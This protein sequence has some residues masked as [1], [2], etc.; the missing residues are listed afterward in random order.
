MV[1]TYQGGSYP[2]GANGW[3]EAVQTCRKEMQFRLARREEEIDE[4]VGPRYASG[5]ADNEKIPMPTIEQ[6][7]TTFQGEFV[8]NNPRVIVDT[9]FPELKADAFEVQQAINFEIVRQNIQ[10]VFEEWVNQSFFGWAPLK[11]GYFSDEAYAQIGGSY[12]EKGVPG[13][14][15]VSPDDW[16][17]DVFSRRQSDCLFYGELVRLEWDYAYES[18]LYDKEMLDNMGP[19]GGVESMLHRNEYGSRRSEALSRG[20]AE[21]QPSYMKFLQCW[22]LYLPRE[23]KLVWV[24]NWGTPEEDKPGKFLREAPWNGPACGPY[25]M[26]SF[27]RV[28]DN[29]QPLSPVQLVFDLHQLINKLQAKL[30]RQAGNAKTVFYA[31]AGA[32]EDAGR[33]AE[34]GDLDVISGK[35]RP[36]QIKELNLSA[37]DNMGAAFLENTI[38]HHSRYA[39]NLD[40]IAGLGPSTETVGQEKLLAASASKRIKYM[41]NRVLKAV[42]KALTSFGQLLYEDPHLELPIVKRM[43]GPVNVTV[44]TVWTPE[45]RR[46]D[47]WNFNFKVSPY[48]MGQRDPKTRVAQVMEAISYAGQATQ[49]N[50]MLQQLG[51]GM[52]I[53]LEGLMRRIAELMDLSELDEILRHHMPQ[54]PFL[55][56][57]PAGSPPDHRSVK[58]PA[59]ERHYVRHNQGTMESAGQQAMQSYMQGPPKQGGA[60]PI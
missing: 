51:A 10:D 13:M 48:S 56:G 14:K 8:A 60:Q 44:R 57:S 43:N 58:P 23:Q 29:M 35:S 9:I 2:K 19:S 52:E 11:V 22:E 34:A 45:M 18:G 38:R 30:G 5:A 54:H 28:P 15:V 27:H 4:Y 55:P 33:V 50:A 49:V 59:T 36:E 12:Y 20:T 53:D 3:F 37:L 25:H 17:Y 40:S 41:Q 39:G 24:P 42:T 1:D 31:E 7:V 46:G 21:Y 26:L 16:V 47:F 6:L 32:A